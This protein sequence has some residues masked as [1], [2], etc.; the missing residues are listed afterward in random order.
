MKEFMILPPLMLEISGAKSAASHINSGYA[1]VDSSDVKTLKTA[2]EIIDQHKKIYKLIGL[3][4][5]LLERDVADL[6]E[7]VNEA[8]KMDAL[9]SNS[10]QSAMGG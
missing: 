4:Q 1:T 7:M 2:M 10:F 9:L 8:E 6:A 5:S 3:Y